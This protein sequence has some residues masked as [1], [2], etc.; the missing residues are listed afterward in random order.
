VAA[1]RSF[2]PSASTEQ[3]MGDSLVEGALGLESGG[4]GA[5]P[6]ERILGAIRPNRSK[7]GEGRVV[8]QKASVTRPYGSRAA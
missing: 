3:G 5:L 4:V 2:A 6:V 7:A 1:P 8:R